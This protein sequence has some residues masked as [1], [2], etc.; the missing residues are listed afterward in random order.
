[1]R[2]IRLSPREPLPRRL[3][4]IFERLGIIIQEHQPD[5]VAIEDVFYAL[6]VNRA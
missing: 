4:T 2:A 5:N 3:A 6:N 1:L